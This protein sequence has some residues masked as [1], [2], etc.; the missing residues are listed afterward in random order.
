MN[1]RFEEYRREL[2]SLHYTQEQKARIAAAVSRT[3]EQKQEQKRHAFFHL[4]KRKAAIAAIAAAALICTAGA[5]ALKTVME[6]FSPIFGGSNTQTE[7]I[8]QMSTEINASATD[9][10]VTIAANAILA[11]VNNACIVYTISWTDDAGIELPDGIPQT[12]EDAYETPT[13]MLQFDQGSGCTL[14]GSSH[15]AVSGINSSYSFL[16]SDPTDNELQLIEF[17]E[18]G[19]DLTSGTASVT[20]QNLRYCY[21]EYGALPENAAWVSLAEGEWSFTFDV[22]CEDLSVSVPLDDQATLETD[23]VQATM[24]E[25]SV[26]PISVYATFAYEVGSKS[27]ET[28]D[29]EAESLQRLYSYLTTT[30][31]QKIYIGGASCSIDDGVAQFTINYVFRSIIP[32]EDMESIT[33]G[34]LT[35][36]IPQN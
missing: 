19:S 17:I 26:S 18:G 11:D 14:G 12:R 33:I 15:S 32:L 7:L 1:N 23:D 36:D 20:F 8:E 9:N 5:V 3:A 6:T 35:Y 27:A 16:D 30:D 31:G 4:P 10:G 29:S 22:D 24:T 25:L 21:L 2:D 34:N 13:V 28:L